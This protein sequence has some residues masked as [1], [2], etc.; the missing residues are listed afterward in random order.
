MLL[1]KFTKLAEGNMKLN[2]IKEIY[3]IGIA[4]IGMSAVAAMAKKMGFKVSGSD[5]KSAYPPAQDVLTENDIPY[6]Q[7]YRAS[8][9]KNPDLVVIGAG[10]NPKDNPEVKAVVKKGIPYLSFP[11][12]LYY[13][14]KDKYRIVVSGTHGKTTTAS[15]IAWALN[16]SKE[17]AGFFI[18]GYLKD[19]KTNYSLSLAKNF[20]IEGDEYYSSFFDQ[21]PKFLHFHPSLLVITNLDM[22]HYDYYRNLND[23]MDKFRKLIKSIPPEGAVV[24]CHDDPLVKKLLNLCDKQIIWYGLK[25]KQIRWKGTRISYSDDYLIFTATNLDTKEKEEIKLKIYGKH[26]V[27]NCL[28]AIA[29]LDYLQIP[30][31]K[32]HEALTGF[33]GPRRRFELKGQV[34]GITVIDDYAHH[35]TAVRTTLEAVKSRYP[36]RKIWAV[37]EPH[38]LS[39]TKATIKELAS[40]FQDAHEV[41]IPNIY[42]AREK[43]KKGRITSQEV[44]NQIK[45][46]NQNVHYLPKKD[47][48]INF[49]I[50]NLRPKDIVIIMAVGDFNQVADLL[51]N[52]LENENN[53][54]LE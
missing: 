4:G 50:K 14:V 6:L 46:F 27:L 41:I 31:K 37:Y 2:K 36:R 51:I 15:L 16:N 32:Y 38:T 22:D 17:K 3:F 34:R 20:V 9:L 21:R 30:I 42:P 54:S 48:V 39:R 11:E 52:K 5:Q 35:P 43:F 19:F 8:N 47:E 18:G 26:N 53:R 23:L 12:L 29:T 40:A 10:E 25:G 28:A 13:L 45:K 44:V 24:A 49:L 33:L 7:G 1:K